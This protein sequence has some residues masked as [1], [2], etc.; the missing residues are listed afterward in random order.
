MIPCIITL[1]TLKII[2]SVPIPL[3]VQN[4]EE[5]CAIVSELHSPAP[6]LWDVN[7]TELICVNAHVAACHL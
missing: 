6:G 5:G 3:S 7:F 1:D 4:K 2:K